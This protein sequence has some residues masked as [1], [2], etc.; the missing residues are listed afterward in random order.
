MI[1]MLH[2]ST[3]NLPSARS[4][5]FGT[6]EVPTV[7]VAVPSVSQCRILVIALVKQQL[8][9]KLLVIVRTEVSIVACCVVYDDVFLICFRALVMSCKHARYIIV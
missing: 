3:R 4:E 2:V 1:V 8:Q 9:S 7:S 5:G 6:K